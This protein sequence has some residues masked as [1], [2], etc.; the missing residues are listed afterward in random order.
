MTPHAAVCMCREEGKLL[1][2][3]FYFSFNKQK[4]SL[5]IPLQWHK[6]LEDRAR[7]VEVTEGEQRRRGQYKSL[8][9]EAKSNAISNKTHVDI[10]CQRQGMVQSIHAK[11]PFQNQDADP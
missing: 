11:S 10:Q 6:V 4:V 1:A 9:T 2:A 3:I 8:Q 5:Q 7:P